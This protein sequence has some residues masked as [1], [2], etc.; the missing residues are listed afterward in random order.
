MNAMRWAIP[1]AV[2]IIFF[3]FLSAVKGILLPFVAGLAIAY[4]FDPIADRLELL[5]LKRW[6]AVLLILLSF[7]I[8]AIVFIVLLAPLVTQQVTALF[9]L[10]PGYAESLRLF[11][12]QIVQQA[13]PG[14]VEGLA[15]DYGSRIFTIISDAVSRFVSGSLAIFNIVSLLL[16]TPLVSFYVLK[17]WDN[18]MAHIDAWLP[19]KYHDVIHDLVSEA[20]SVLSGFVRGQLLVASIMGLLYALGWSVIGLDYAVVLALIAAMLCLIP[21]VGPLTGSLLALLVGFGQFGDDA[22]R[23][24]AIFGVHVAVQLF[25]GNFLTPRIVGQRVGLDDVWVI[26]AVLAG[27]ELMGIVGILIAVPMA[28]VIAVLLRFG[29]KKYLESDLYGA[30]P[31]DFDDTSAGPS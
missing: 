16:L 20:D 2:I 27:A 23:L 28:A 3:A 12:D 31:P 10:L 1:I 19:R 8:F 24:V 29:L 18:M 5:G 4:L 26:F 22:V 21:Y 13:G 9:R 30:P 15:Q 17:D 14:R 6:L 7:F 11:I 25:E